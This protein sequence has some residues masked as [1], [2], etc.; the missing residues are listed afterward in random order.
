MKILIYFLQKDLY[1]MKI[2]KL[3]KKNLELLII[4]LEIMIIEFLKFLLLILK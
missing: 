1:S 2:L 4:K 3:M